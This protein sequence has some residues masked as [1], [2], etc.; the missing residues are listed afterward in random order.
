MVNQTGTKQA[1]KGPP[2][3]CSLGYQTQSSHEAQI[4]STRVVALVIQEESGTLRIL[5]EPR[6]QALVK[7]EDREQI[8]A[9]L[10]DLVDR[11]KVDVDALFNQLS[12][13]N[14]GPL[15]TESMGRRVADD[16]KLAAE[17]QHFVP[18]G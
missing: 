12:S 6:L 10:K 1:E 11:A 14:W 15:V 8:D 2:R 17:T 3:F 18:I 9:L 5:A 13:L 4:A 7:D 16:P